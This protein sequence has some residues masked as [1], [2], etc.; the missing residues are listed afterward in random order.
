MHGKNARAAF[1]RE[2]ND[3]A[4]KSI[5]RTARTIGGD[6]G[7][8]AGSNVIGQLQ[9]GS[10]ALART[11]SAHNVEPEPAHKFDIPGAVATGADERCALAMRKK[12]A[13]RERK[14][15]QAIVPSHA[16]ETLRK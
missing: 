4:P 11:G 5:N 6:D 3:A 9:Q 10:C 13:D 15:K 1:L 14:K 2:E 8:T 12:A 16:N 7:V